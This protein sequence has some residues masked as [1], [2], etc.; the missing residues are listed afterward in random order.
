MRT[1]ETVFNACANSR[2]ENT[3]LGIELYCAK[4]GPYS[5]LNCTEFCPDFTPVIPGSSDPDA[6]EFDVS[7]AVDA[8]A[9]IRVKTNN[10]EQAKEMA[11]NAFIDY[12]CGNLEIIDTS[13][14]NCEDKN[15]KIIDYD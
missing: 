10:P 4:H 11:L 14:V 1:S 9:H 6:Q 13:P 3:A 2:D 8:R 5:G 7:I 12:D 15:G